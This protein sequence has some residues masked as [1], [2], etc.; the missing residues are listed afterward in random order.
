MS[1]LPS[2][3]ATQYVRKRVNAQMSYR[4]EIYRNGAPE[5]DSETGVYT[6]TKGLMIYEGI[7]RMYYLDGGGTINVGDGDIVTGGTYISIPFE[8]DPV[9]H[10]DD[11][12]I[13]T[14]SQ[15]PDL[16]GAAFRITSVDGGSYLH[17][18]RR[19]Q[20]TVWAPNRTWTG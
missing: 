15:D 1:R 3:R 17:A 4:V 8:A 14:K 19:L 13:I 12:V 7:A 10:V 11:T 5:F 9:P 6:A 20:V 16:V 18:A 2:K